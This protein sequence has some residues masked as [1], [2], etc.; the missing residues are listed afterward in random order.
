MGNGEPAAAE[1]VALA[2]EIVISVASDDEHSLALTAE[3]ALFSF[4]N[5]GNG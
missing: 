1:L 4:G 2:N 3:G 5:S